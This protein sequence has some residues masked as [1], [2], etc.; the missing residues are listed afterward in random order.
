MKFME[1][2]EFYRYYK[3]FGPTLSKIL[4]INENKLK[5]VESNSFHVFSKSLSVFCRIFLVF[6]RTLVSVVSPFIMCT[7][8]QGMME[9][10]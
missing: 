7:F 3:R 8:P 1:K 6:K 2:F 9:C 5:S 10:R 4:A